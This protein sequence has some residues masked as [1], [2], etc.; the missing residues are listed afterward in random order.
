MIAIEHIVPTLAD[1]ASAYVLH[2]GMRRACA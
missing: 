1:M 2:V